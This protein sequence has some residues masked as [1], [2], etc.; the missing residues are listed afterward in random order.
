M[1][2]ARGVLG[3]RYLL[4]LDISC[5]LWVDTDAGGRVALD[6]HLELSPRLSLIGH[7]E[8]DTHDYWEARVGLSYMLDR[9]VSVTGQWHSEYRWGAGVGIRF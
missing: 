5:R 2:K 8:Y 6:K 1:E 4:P 9:N 3:L 7:V